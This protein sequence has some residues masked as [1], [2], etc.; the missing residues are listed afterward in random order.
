MRRKT[1]DFFIWMIIL[2]VLAPGAMV[3]ALGFAGPQPL[4]AHLTVLGGVLILGV[5]SFF[6]GER[7][8]LRYPYLFKEDKED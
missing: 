8:K 5:I 3:V 7:L 2:L 6:V 1:K 4:R